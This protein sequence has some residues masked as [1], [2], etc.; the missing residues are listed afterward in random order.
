MQYSGI[1]NFE[2]FFLSFPIL[3]DFSSS[4]ARNL[5]RIWQYQITIRYV[6]REKIAGNLKKDNWSPF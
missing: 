2:D 6:K 1:R 3:W 5:C 4:E